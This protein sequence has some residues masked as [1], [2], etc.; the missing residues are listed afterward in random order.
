[1]F[2]YPAGVF[3]DKQLSLQHL[4]QL[5]FDIRVILN[6]ILKLAGHRTEIQLQ[7]PDLQLLVPYYAH[8][9]LL[10]TFLLIYSLLENL[11]LFVQLVIALYFLIFYVFLLFLYSIFLIDNGLLLLLILIENLGLFIRLTLDLL[12]LQIIFALY[13]DTVFT[14]FH[15]YTLHIQIMMLLLMLILLFL[16]LYSLLLILLFLMLLVKMGLQYQDTISL[17][18][19]K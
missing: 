11:S 19:Y 15:L 10:F 17:I 14:L 8:I 5:A 4:I 16:Y 7:F 18:F 9:V 12:N 6:I 13:L 2:S 3:P 1:M